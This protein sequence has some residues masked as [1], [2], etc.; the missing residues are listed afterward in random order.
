MAG[1][2]EKRTQTTAAPRCCPKATKQINSSE[3]CAAQ[4]QH[5]GFE[6]YPQT[7]AKKEN[8]KALAGKGN[9]SILYVQR[10]KE[11]KRKKLRK[12]LG[13]ERYKDGGFERYWYSWA[14]TFP[15]TFHKDDVISSYGVGQSVSHLW[16][17]FETISLNLSKHILNWGIRSYAVCLSVRLCLFVANTVASRE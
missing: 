17:R 9:E 10:Q 6:I 11:R 7:E 3:K 13:I 1:L 5:T 8:G 16:E 15:S 12:K 2:W 14:P 4:D